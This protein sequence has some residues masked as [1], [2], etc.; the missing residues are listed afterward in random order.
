MFDVAW[1]RHL[2]EYVPSGASPSGVSIGLT[3]SM[4]SRILAVASERTLTSW[5]LVNAM[6]FPLIQ[7]NSASPALLMSTNATMASS[8]VKPAC[9]VR[10]C[11]NP[12]REPSLTLGPSPEGLIFTRIFS[13]HKGY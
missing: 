8:K 11:A 5:I 7:L 6:I 3:R 2:I 4:Y 9:R 12:T 1:E 10:E 13:E